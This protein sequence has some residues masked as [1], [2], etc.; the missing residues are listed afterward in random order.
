M[1]FPWVLV[2]GLGI[3]NFKI[4][5]HNFPEFPGVKKLVFSRIS[6]GNLTNLKFLEGEFQESIPTHPP[7]KELG[8]PLVLKK[9]LVFG[10]G[11][12]MGCNT[13]FPGLRGEASFCLEF[14]E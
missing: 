1:K 11:S 12:S 9:V 8:L 2:F 13:I 5:G 10:P 4:V 7:K 14:L 3:S 6:K